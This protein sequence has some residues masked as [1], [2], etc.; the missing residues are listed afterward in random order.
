MK[1]NLK[2]FFTA[3]LVLVSGLSYAGINFD[4]LNLNERNKA[5]YTVTQNVSGIKPYSVLFSYIL[6]GEESVSGANLPDILT[7]YPEH[8]SALNNGNAMQ[9]RNRY[10]TAVYDFEKEK[11]TWIARSSILPEKSYSLSPIVTS[12]DGA[13]CVFMR[14]V[15][16]STGELII[17]NVDT[18]KYVILDKEAAYSYT[19]LPVKWAADSR[20][21]VYEKG[22]QV[23]FCN[24]VNMFKGVQIEE[25]YRRIGKGKITTVQWC[26]NTTIAYLDSDIIYL[27]DARELSSLG[28]YSKFYDLGKVIGRLPEKFNGENMEFR[29]SEKADQLLLIKNNNFVSYYSINLRDTSDYVKLLNFKSYTDVFEG[30]Y[31]FEILWPENSK[32][33]VWTD[34]IS[35]NGKISS[36]VYIFNDRNEMIKVLAVEDTTSNAA[37]S[38]DGKYIAFSSGVSAYIYSLNPWGKI[39]EVKGE[40]VAS[41]CW[42]DKTSLCIGGEQSVKLY[43]LASR[44]EKYLFLSQCRSATWDKGTGRII[45][46]TDVYSDYFIYDDYRNTWSPATSVVPSKAEVQNGNYRIYKAAAKNT[47]Y[48][49][50]IYVRHL[51]GK[52]NTFP[53]YKE[54]VQKNT[55][56]KKIAIVFDLMDSADGVSSILA[57]CEKYSIK[58]TFFING[59]FIRRYPKEVNRIAAS[60]AEVGSMFYTCTDLTS[61]DY[62]IDEDY[63]RRGLARNEDEYYE[64]TGGEL[65]L[66]WHA[67]YYRS[68]K[69]IREAGSLAGYSYID[70]PVELSAMDSKAGKTMESQIIPITVGLKS[71]TE[72]NVFYAKLEL[73]I[74]SLLDGDYEIVPV[75][76]L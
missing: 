30:S 28:I 23:F 69:M 8:M 65:S 11:L 53:L 52:T 34:Y 25:K 36:A 48:D 71:D 18:K 42:K 59:E 39:A 54:V 32:P 63:I 64:C 13:W 4:N 24:P 61:K 68:N 9:V 44:A 16:S 76:G 6:K 14:K 37:I 67:P 73:L 58:P 74:N 72:K 75:S 70:F 17:Q 66:M 43:S 31:K 2:A 47:R 7:C 5:L 40:K 12:P 51:S 3:G 62:N 55:A 46:L 27:I 57:L 49:N 10:G 60:G 21:F 19:E 20:S 33:V 56:K 1:K 35:D 41:L 15:S 26:N 29:I 50:G 45:A 22:G 38:P